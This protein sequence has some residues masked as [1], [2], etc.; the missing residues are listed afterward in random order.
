VFK[1]R[2]HDGESAD[3][4]FQTIDERRGDQV[5]FTAINV[6][7]QMPAMS[8]NELK[9]VRFWEEEN[10]MLEDD[11]SLY[12]FNPGTMDDELAEFY[13]NGSWQVLRTWINDKGLQY[14][15]LKKSPAGF[16][17]STRLV[18]YTEEKPYMR[19]QRPPRAGQEGRSI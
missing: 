19:I 18:E 4:V 7:A 5:L 16:L 6:E 9:R 2:V 1:P 12:F 8:T 13:K 3:E 17:G 15:K 14:L 10:L 11:T